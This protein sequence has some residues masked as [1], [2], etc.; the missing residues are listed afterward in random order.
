MTRRAVQQLKHYT[1]L[2]VKGKAVAA[3]HRL[4]LTSGT[5]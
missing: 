5:S 1:I 4:V 2:Q 3:S